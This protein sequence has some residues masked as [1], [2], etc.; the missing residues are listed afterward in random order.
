M[1]PHKSVLKIT[2]RVTL[3]AAVVWSASACSHSKSP[4]ASEQYPPSISS[5]SSQA[6]SSGTPGTP[7]SSASQDPEVLKDAT[8]GINTLNTMD[9]RAVDGDLQAWLAATSGSLHTQMTQTAAMLRL[10][11]A[12]QH[13]TMNGKILTIRVDALSQTAGTAQVSGTDDVRLQT[14]GSDKTAHDRFQ[15]QL[16]RTAGGWKLT[17]YDNAAVS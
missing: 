1:T 4:V 7:T 17:R 5:S 15:A 9:Y 14:P 12:N 16:T 10:Q 6:I 11:F 8:A 3:A 2:G 13:I